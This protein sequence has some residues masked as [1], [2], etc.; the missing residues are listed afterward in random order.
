MSRSPNA[1]MISSDDL[2]REVVLEGRVAQIPWQHLIRTDA[3][4]EIIYIDLDD[5]DQIVAYV[6]GG[7]RCGGRLRLEG[8]VIEVRGL[9]KRP[10]SDEAFVDYQLDVSAWDCIEGDDEPFSATLDDLNDL[11]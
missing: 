2:G 10:G 4:K 3:D 1:A 7:L 11:E 5:G 6:E 9:S 8:T